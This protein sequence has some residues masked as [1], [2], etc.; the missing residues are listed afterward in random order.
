MTEKIPTLRWT[1]IYFTH[2]IEAQRRSNSGGQKGMCRTPYWPNYK[3][4]QSPTH[5]YKSL[6]ASGQIGSAKIIVVN[7]SYVC[8]DREELT[9]V[10]KQSIGT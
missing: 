8:V 5:H 2:T 7:K 3:G 6:P 4:K 10:K 1:T 9:G